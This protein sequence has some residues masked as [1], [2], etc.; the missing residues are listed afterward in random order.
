MKYIPVVNKEKIGENIR[1]LRKKHGLTMQDLSDKLEFG[2]VQNVFKWEHGINMPSI[3]NLVVLST[4]FG[5]LI[6]EML[7]VDMVK[8]W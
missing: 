7:H 8:I 1:Q 4:I 2:H 5:V 6:E 3:D